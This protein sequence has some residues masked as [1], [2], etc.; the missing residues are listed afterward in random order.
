MSKHVEQ[1]IAILG[2][3]HENYVLL[4]A[5][6]KHTCK[7][8]YDN[9]FA[10]RGLLSVAKNTIDETFGSGMNFF[11]IDFSPPSGD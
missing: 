2:E 9:Y 4:V 10:A 1:A 5:D 8:A 3:H 7:L 6:T 11:E